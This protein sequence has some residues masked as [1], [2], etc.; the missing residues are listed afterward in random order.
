MNASAAH[1]SAGL[2]R[3][4]HVSLG[5]IVVVCCLAAPNAA[6]GG[7]VGDVRY[8]YV[9][10]G[11]TV[12]TDVGG[13]I[14]VACDA[15]G[16]VTI[17]EQAISNPTGGAIKAD[18]VVKIMVDAANGHHNEIDLSGVKPECFPLLQPDQPTY[19]LDLGHVEDGGD[20]LITTEGADDEFGLTACCATTPTLLFVL[21]SALALLSSR[22]RGH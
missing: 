15:N 12:V 21:A 4:G 11:L 2:S 22:R 9:D 18:E 1:E 3:R 5:V 10:D 6:V 17:N 8:Y 19:T 14:A 13:R 16:N 7:M 20:Y